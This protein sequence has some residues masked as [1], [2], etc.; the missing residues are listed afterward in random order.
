MR[1]HYVIMPHKSGKPYNIQQVVNATSKL[2][3]AYR[4]KANMLFVPFVYLVHERRILTIEDANVTMHAFSQ[5][6]TLGKLHHNV[7][8]PAREQRCYDL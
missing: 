7:L 4:L 3:D 1:M 5:R 6:K 2:V 8:S